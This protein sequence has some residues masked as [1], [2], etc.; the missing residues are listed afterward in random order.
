MGMPDFFRNHGVGAWILRDL[1][2]KG[3]IDLEDVQ[4]EIL[5]TSQ[6]GVACTKV[7]YQDTDPMLPELPQGLQTPVGGV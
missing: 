7:V 5:E 1:P 2:D 4:R 3:L 6:G